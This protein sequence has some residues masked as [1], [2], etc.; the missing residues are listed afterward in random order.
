MLSAL[1][2]FHQNS[3]DLLTGTLLSTLRHTMKPS[4]TTRGFEKRQTFRD[5]LGVLNRI[6][7][8]T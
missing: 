5:R 4:E 8:N 6:H 2:A 3:G 7:F 1:G